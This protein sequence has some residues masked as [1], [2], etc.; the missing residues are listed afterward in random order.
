VAGGSAEV[1][2]RDLETIDEM[3]ACVRLQ[4]MTW[5]RDFTE[6]VPLS[7]LKVGR[8]L[9]GVSAGAFL[10]DGRLVGFVF[11]LTGLTT[12][13]PAHWSDMLAV[14]PD[15]RRGGIG[16]R[17]KLFQRE[18]VL[19]LGVP[20]MYWTFDPLE[21]RNARLNLRRLGGYGSEYVPD[22]YGPSVSPLHLGL[23][24]DRL[25][26]RWD[27]DSPRV[28][29]ALA[30]QLPAPGV[31]HRD[32]GVRAFE[33]AREGDW[34]VP[35][36]EIRVMSPDTRYVVP[37]PERI[38]ELHAAAPELARRWRAACR[39]ALAGALAAGGRVVDVFADQG[40]SAYLVVPEQM[41]GEP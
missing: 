28:E 10:P 39:A 23:A 33:V 30:G 20:T 12:E 4:E 13:G 41:M 29:R 31:G 24:T 18:R 1:T 19:S 37:V 32:V 2:I 27:L 16:R 34:P 21:V 25:V 26:V 22:M 5:G 15:F 40:E 3:R 38:G 11:G 9:G 8:R 17:L 7:I 6:K 14:A 36:G 35:S